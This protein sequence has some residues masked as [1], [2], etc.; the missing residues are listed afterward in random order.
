MLRLAPLLLCAALLSAQAPAPAHA[1]VVIGDLH[2]GPGRQAEA[3]SPL[4]RYAFPS[5]I[6]SIA[7]VTASISAMPSTRE[8]SP[9]AR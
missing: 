2:M 1:I 8:T 6:A 5:R 9:R 3:A 7:R 4:R